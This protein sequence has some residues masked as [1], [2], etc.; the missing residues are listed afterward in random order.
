MTKVVHAS[1]EE[2]ESW[3]RSRRADVAALELVDATL[4]LLDAAIAEPTA[5][6]AM[7]KASVSP[8]WE[9]FPEAL[10]ILRDNLARDPG[11][12]WG[13]TLFVL[14]SPRTLIG[15]GG[16]KGPPKEGVVEIGYAVAPAF[17][18]R[19]LAT[20]AAR[21]LVHR[22]FTDRRVTAVDAHTLS[23]PNASVRVL[24]KLGMQRMDAH[25]FDNQEVW[26]WRLRRTT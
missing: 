12:P 23:H 13:T 25:S 6:P 15:M 22:A 18:G 11:C 19:G 8:D 16:F 3:L 14:T 26:H 1:H 4:P 2:I 10:P 17:Q 24:E 21:Q 20:E 9:G 7:L 5:L